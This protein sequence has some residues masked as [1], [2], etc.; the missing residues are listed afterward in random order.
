MKKYIY[1]LLAAIAMLTSCTN[2][3]IDIKYEKDEHFYQTF[4]Y[5]VSTQQTY[6]T[7]NA[8]TALKNRFLSGES[9]DYY[10][11]V[12]TFIYNAD[13]NL[14]DNNVDFSKTFGSVSHDFNLEYGKY[15]AV[16]VEMIVDKDDN[17]RSD[18]F[19]LTDTD[20][21]SSI[22][23]AYRY[24]INEGK[25][26][27]VTSSIWYEAVGVS[28]QE[29]I[30]DSNTKTLSITP[31]AIGCVIECEFSNFN[32][33]KDKDILVLSTKNCP[34]GRKLD[35]RLNGDDRFVYEEYNSGINAELRWYR[36]STTAF[37]EHEGFDVYLL[38]EGDALDCGIGAG[39]VIG[40]NAT[41]KSFN[42]AKFVDGRT[43]YGGL[44]YVGKANSDGLYGGIFETTSEYDT[45]YNQA[46]NMYVPDAQPLSLMTPNTKWKSTVSS[47]QSS[48]SGYTMVV[49]SNGKAEQLPSGSY[50]IA[51]SGKGSENLIAYYFDTM[52]TGLNE[53]D[54]YYAKSTTKQADIKSALDKNY[55]FIAESDGMYMYANSAFDTIILLMDT[56][57]DYVVGYVDADVVLNSPSYK[58]YAQ[59]KA[60][61]IK[62]SP[63]KP[64]VKIECS[65]KI[66]IPFKPAKAMNRM[67]IMK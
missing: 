59:N 40:T 67:N 27:Y 58:T 13:G 62:Y 56:T 47:V 60:K 61:T 42:K 37:D 21:L 38:E 57:D 5:N 10:L 49:G 17:Y 64:T 28:T 63:V 31:K 24:S 52:T 3:D 6:D 25:K 18:A 45:W 32:K 41:W 33:C 8:T 39:N 34:I 46:K 43:Y 35:P 23:V 29:F 16:T 1:T 66:K 65:S 53:A 20:K 54:V 19:E 55:T 30:V 22:Q 26:E 2:D 51:Y 14:V 48:M 11:G 7:F 12:Y 4:T 50:A 9:G 36:Y 15:T 44:Y